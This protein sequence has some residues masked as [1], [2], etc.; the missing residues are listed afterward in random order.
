MK[1]KERKEQIREGMLSDGS[2]ERQEELS[3]HQSSSNDKG[4]PGA[5]CCSPGRE[6]GATRWVVSAT[7]AYIL[8]GDRQE[9]NTHRSTSCSNRYDNSRERWEADPGEAASEQ[10][11]SGRL[12]I[13]T[14]PDALLTSQSSWSSVLTSATLSLLP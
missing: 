7:E 8:W 1:G 2:M 6:T 3:F 12:R 5:R 14:N 11:L 13:H 4:P 10:S 9:V